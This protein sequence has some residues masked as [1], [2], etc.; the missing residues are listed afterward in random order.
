MDLWL[1]LGKALLQ[2]V[3]DGWVGTA[4]PA[5]QAAKSYKD[6]ACM[7]MERAQPEFLNLAKRVVTLG[8]A[9]QIDFQNVSQRRSEECTFE[10]LGICVIIWEWKAK[11]ETA[12]KH[13]K[14]CCRTC[15]GKVMKS[16]VAWCLSFDLSGWLGS[17][18]SFLLLYR[19][20][21]SVSG[22]DSVC[23]LAAICGIEFKRLFCFKVV[24]FCW[25]W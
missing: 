24:S 8:I 4:T 14:C 9:I 11:R 15:T 3:E 22:R 1:T 25:S 23:S 2:H 13:L 6:L 19:S 7:T 12:E 20:I 16:E 21:P 5:L 10:C 18:P 17:T